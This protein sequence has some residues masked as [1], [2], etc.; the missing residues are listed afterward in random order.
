MTVRVSSPP[1][2]VRQ[3]SHLLTVLAAI[4]IVVLAQYLPALA[5]RTAMTSAEVEA[6]SARIGWTSAAASHHLAADIAERVNE[7]R[8]S[9]GL[10]PL[11]WHQDLAVMAQTWSEEMLA[12]GY[13]HSSAEYRQ[14][15]ELHGIGE[16]ILMGFTDSGEAHLAWMESDGHRQNLLLP[17]Y[18]HIGI[19]V[20][21]RNDGLI[22]A[23]QLLGMPNTVYPAGPLEVPPL[24]TVVRPDRGIK[25]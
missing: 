3:G 9:R 12:T 25:C 17:E 6:Q 16:N 8:V 14:H 5:Q 20:V 19:G 4:A 13:R 22:W 7:E 21:C 23:T 11:Q 2:G 10:A 18:T 1:F 24:D 15:P